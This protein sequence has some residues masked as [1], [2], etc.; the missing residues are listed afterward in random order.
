LKLVSIYPLSKLAQQRPSH[1]LQR[2]ILLSLGHHCF[3]KLDFEIQQ[4]PL[5]TYETFWYLK[6]L[7][8]MNFG[9]SVHGR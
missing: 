2:W 4:S 8:C 5:Q 9:L 3:K 1:Q 7:T 6:Y